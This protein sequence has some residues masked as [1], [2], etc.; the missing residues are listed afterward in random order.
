MKKFRIPVSWTMESDVI[1]E[2][3]NLEQAI[4]RAKDG[5]LPNDDDSSYIECSFQVSAA[6]IDENPHYYVELKDKGGDE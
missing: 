6:L 2:A 4:E 1:V 3:E 5:P